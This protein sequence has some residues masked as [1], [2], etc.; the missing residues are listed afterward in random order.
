MDEKNELAS[1][2]DELSLR[3]DMEKKRIKE[4]FQASEARIKAEYEKRLKDTTNAFKEKLNNLQIDLNSLKGMLAGLMI[5]CY[6]NTTN[7]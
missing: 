4:K 6:N 7:S 5:N 1:K 3:T 2:L